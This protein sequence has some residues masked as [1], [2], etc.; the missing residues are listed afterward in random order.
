MNAVASQVIIKP[1][2]LMAESKL[3]SDVSNDYLHRLVPFPD[4][5]ETFFH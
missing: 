3:L 2:T 1:G 5:C 4:D